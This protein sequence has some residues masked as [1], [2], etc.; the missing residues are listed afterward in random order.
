[1]L[2]TE[3]EVAIMATAKQPGLRAADRQVRLD[4]IMD[5]FALAGRCAGSRILELGPGHFEF[6]ELARDAG[7]L[8]VVAVDNDPAVVQLGE[9]RGFRT[10]EMDIREI[11]LDSLGG[12][13][14]GIF[15]RSSFNAV[16]FGVSREVHEEWADRLASL[17]AADAW[18][19]LAPWNYRIPE[20]SLDTTLTAIRHQVDTLVRRG[21][22]AFRLGSELAHHYRMPG[23]QEPQREML[24]IRN[25]DVPQS[26]REGIISRTD[27]RG[28]QAAMGWPLLDAAAPTGALASSSPAP[29]VSQDGRRE[30]GQP[31]TVV[32][33]RR[34]RRTAPPTEIPSQTRAWGVLPWEY[35]SGFVD[36]LDRCRDRV[37]VVTY[38][39]LEWDDDY[40]HVHKYPLELQNWRRQ[41]NER[42]DE[43]IHVL[44]Q[45]DVDFAPERTNRLVE[46]EI[47]RDVPANVM[48]FARY[49]NRGRLASRGELVFE[50]YAVDRALLRDAEREHGFVIGYHTCCVEHA[51][52]DLDEAVK[53]F[54][55]DLE[56]MRQ[57]FDVRYFS[58]HG[59]VPGPNGE[60]NFD[61]PLTEQHIRQARWVHNRFS[62]SWRNDWSD[63]AFL[64]RPADDLRE[65]VRAW[66]PGDR[67]RVLIH[68]QYYAED[69][70]RHPKLEQ[71]EWVQQVYDAYERGERDFWS[72]VQPGEG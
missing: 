62:P 58:P 19:W 43:R 67:Y 44:L 18:A 35:V 21:F 64:T 1:V 14:D 7:A 25:L 46:L 28:F 56:A 16:W 66:L 57:D 20:P 70:V 38:D 50:P 4:E 30:P 27:A 31:S 37:R 5:D 13:F 72:D 24:I 49:H 17:L 59:G 52:W 60:H 11:S 12:P 36:M 23:S 65:F 47:A 29:S 69:F 3:N 54:E 71:V 61:V 6:A 53:V 22:L 51:L 41:K 45:H 40:D 26:V 42:H 33:P 8:E 39:D 32:W 9:A 34:G 10:L 48:I 2:R 68:S 63:G 15:C 55:A